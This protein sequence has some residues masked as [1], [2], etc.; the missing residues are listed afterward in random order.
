[1]FAFATPVGISIG[2]ATSTVGHGSAS[3]AMSA[4]ASGTFLYV[5][6]NEVI[7]KELE[8]PDG[9][10][11]IKAAVRG[12]KFVA[13]AVWV[14]TALIKA[15]R[16][17]DIGPPGRGRNV[18]HQCGVEGDVPL[19]SKPCVV[20]EVHQ[21]PITAVAAGKLNSAVIVGNEEV[22][23]FGDGTSGK[24]GLG[25]ACAVNSPSRME[26]FIGRSAIRHVSL[27]LHH[28]LFLDQAGHLWACGENKEGQ[29]GLGLPLEVL[30]S[31]HRRAF[32]QSLSQT[33]PALST[34]QDESVSDGLANLLESAAPSNVHKGEV[35]TFGADY[36]GAL[37]SEASWVSSAH[38]VSA[39]ISAAIAADG[40]AVGVA[41]GSTFC[42]A[43]T[44]SG[45]V[46]V[47]GK[48]AGGLAV[49]PGLTA[50][51]AAA[52]GVDGCMSQA[53]DGAGGMFARVQLPAGVKIRYIAAGQ[54]HLLMGDEERVWVVGRWLDADGQEAGSASWQHPQQVLSL[55]DEGISKI[56]AGMHSCA[57]VTQDSRLWLWGRLMDNV[58]AQGIVRRFGGEKHAA[59]VD[60]SSCWFGGAEPRLVGELQGVRD[61]ALGGWHA[62]AVV[63]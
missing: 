33:H 12:G 32:C 45:S 20:L 57:V 7:P 61:V 5:A 4:L 49:A 52:R 37:G 21:Q 23:V 14:Q 34:Q 10:R 9:H 54:Q 55:P 19:V 44:P 30:A 18:E 28:S 38:Q 35:W 40:G 31:Q 47:W 16:N 60:W 62:L 2:F 58:H 41:A 46:V 48:L 6:L 29:C 50:A 36:N 53:E 15:A 43:L 59:G 42:A 8:H 63:D 11:L 3:A 56:A 13:Q 25:T 17:N 51:A 27:G 1:M 24:L 26:A 22:Y 39:P